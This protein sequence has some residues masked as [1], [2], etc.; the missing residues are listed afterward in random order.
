MIVNGTLTITGNVNA[1]SPYSV[2]ASGT[3]TIGSSGVV[4]Y[5]QGAALTGTKGALPVATWQTGSTL[6]V[7]STGGT[8][9]TS[10][11]AGGGQ[12]FYNLNWNC[13]SQT[14]NFGLSLY[15]NTIG[16]TVSI[17]NTGSGRVQFFASNNG[18][19]NIMGD[20]IVSGSASTT[21]KGTTSATI[22]TLNIYGKVNVNTTGSFAVSRG[23]QG[24]AGTST[25][26][27]RGDSIKIIAG[28]IQ[29]SDTGSAVGKFV[30]KKNGSQYLTIVPTTLT[31]NGTP[32]EVDA[33]ATV[34]LLS[35]VNVTT[36]YLN[37]GIIVST[38]TNPFLIMGWWTGSTLTSGNISLLAPGSLTS[39]VSG[40]M[41]YLYATLRRDNNKKLSN[42]KKMEFIVLYL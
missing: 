38:A 41:A 34:N 29:N 5:N 28:T 32:I 9:A 37:G 19:L 21:I 1:A 17:L 15:A 23:T 20:L 3:L 42:W 36:L 14:G 18:T 27:F 7:N 22:D 31:G 26:V 24:N 40:P 11:G 10:F 12:N 6:N 2:M 25:M 33:G 30:F 35:P 8:A 4:N 39:F 16:G 13:P